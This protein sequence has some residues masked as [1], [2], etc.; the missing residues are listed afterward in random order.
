MTLAGPVALTLIG[1]PDTPARDAA[2]DALGPWV[3]QWRARLAELGVPLPLGLAADL[4]YDLRSQ[5]FR[6]MPR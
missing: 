4:V 2:I 1:D 5:S 3:P 6:E